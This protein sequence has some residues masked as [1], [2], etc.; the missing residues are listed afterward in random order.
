M[1][2]KKNKPLVSVIMN[3]RNG[4]KYLKQSIRSVVNQ[5]YL[6]WELVFFDNQSS[7]NSKRILKSFK[8]RRLKYFKSKKYLKLYN[9]RNLAIKKA[10]GKYICFLDTDDF[11]KKDKINKQVNFLEKKPQY[12]MVY[13]NFY[14]LNE[15]KNELFIKDN[16]LPEGNITKEI[17]K[18]YSI[19]ILTVCL[20]KKIFNKY[21]FKKNYN[22]IGDFD[23][24]V[25]LSKKINIGCI[26]SPL[27]YYRTHNF[28]YSKIKIDSYITEL[29]KW[30]NQNEN[31]LSSKGYNLNYQKIFLIKLIIKYF[32][33]K[34]GRVVQW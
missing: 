9:A 25:K 5:S 19:G 34:I 2:I 1:K 4:E 29:K 10:N 28:N 11:W 14:T 16:I 30:I 33:I 22:F 21:K 18:K 31:K 12:D 8:D 13:S 23:F 7:D 24:F 27:A 17:L 32:F 26:Q 6:R 3:C 15:N 20:R